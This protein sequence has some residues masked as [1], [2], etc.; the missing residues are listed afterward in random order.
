MTIKAHFDGKVFVPEEPPELPAGE[1]LELEIH[2]SPGTPTALT[3]VE[4]AKS[5]LFGMW[6]DRSDITD[7]TEFSRT[8]RRDIERRVR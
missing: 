8:L 3:G 5:D 2:R 6:A 1:K 7:S 4:L